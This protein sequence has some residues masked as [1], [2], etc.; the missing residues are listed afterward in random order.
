MAALERG[1]NK[2]ILLRLTGKGLFIIS[3][4]LES[5]TTEVVAQQTVPARVVWLHYGGLRGVV[6][7]DYSPRCST[8]G[9]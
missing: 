2:E 4:M 6:Q 9:Y 1:N 7:P 8:E 3:D 5:K